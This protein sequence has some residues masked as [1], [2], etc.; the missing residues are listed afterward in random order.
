MSLWLKFGCFLTGWDSAVLG[1]CSPASKSKL[2]KYTSALLILM[3]IWGTIGFCFAERY[4]GL[5]LW[6]CPISSLIFITIVVMIERQ[7]LLSIRPKI[8]MVIFRSLIAIAMALIGATI[9]DQTMFG[10][11]IDKQM[12]LTIEEQADTLAQK[13]S[14]TIDKQLAIIKAEKDSLKRT[15]EVLQADVN[16]NPLIKQKSVTYNQQKTVGDDSG[17]AIKNTSVTTSQIPNPKIKTI[18]DNNDKLEKLEKREIEKYAERM[19]VDSIAR[20]ECK[21]NVGFLEELEAMYTIA[22]TRPVAGTFYIIFF[23]LMVSLELFIVFSKMGDKECDYEMA[24][25]GAAELKKKQFNQAF[26][27]AASSSNNI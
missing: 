21:E 10:K 11:D 18:E 15:N 12:S 19:S 4:V 9:F 22:T 23:I 2:S 13:R 20:A 5:P 17:K 26:N 16:A 25:E 14:A 1:Q 7:I 3:I 24:I 6:A 27:R 8:G